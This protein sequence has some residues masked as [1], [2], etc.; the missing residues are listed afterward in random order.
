MK[1]KRRAT[2]F[3][4]MTPAQ[5]ARA[6]AEFDREMVIAEFRPLTPRERARWEKTRR[7]R[8]RPR[9]GQGAK[10]VSVSVERGLLARSDAL[11]HKLGIPRA[12][13]IERG[14]KAVLA[15]AGQA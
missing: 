13:L 3:G 7:K 2:Q 14:L 6:T 11:A 9:K 8:G 5:L 4:R 10:V 12:V 15:V 1:H